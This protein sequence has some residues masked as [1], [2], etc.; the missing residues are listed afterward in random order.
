[1][2]GRTLERIR[3]GLEKFGLAP[4]IV[5]MEH[6]GAV[7]SAGDPLP[8]ITTANGGA[9]GVALP[10]LVH[11][12][13]TGTVK[14]LA[15]PLPSLCGGGKHF[16]LCEP[17][18]TGQQSGAVARSVDEPV[19][20]VATA[21][22][23]AMCA[24]YLVKYNGTGGALSVDLPLDT[25]STRDRFGLVQPTVVV[26]GERYLLD[27]HF[28]ML[29]AHELAAAQGFPAGYKFMGNTSQV[30]KQIGNAVPKNLS[31]ALVKSALSQKS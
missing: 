22:A 25:I 13:G 12:R 31:K 17:F 11:L 24:P 4:S 21:G 14:S 2:T 27:I 5:C 8:T 9:M 28:R 23:I 19:P 16:G 18:L 20:T 15:D 26:N 7:R 1:M 6:R 3:I 30:V 29:K 10:F